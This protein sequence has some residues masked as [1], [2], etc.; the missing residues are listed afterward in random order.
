MLPTFDSARDEVLGLFHT[1]WIADT[2]A[3]NGGS[4][5]PVHYQGTDE[6]DPPAANHAYA[7]IT[8]RHT[9]SRAAAFGQD[10]IRRHTRPGLVTVQVFSPLIVQAGLSFAENAAIIARDAFEGVGT[11]SGIWFRNARIQEIGPTAAWFQV[12]VIAEFE[13]DEVK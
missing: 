2:P 5:I 4:A 7:R 8:I 9:T 11:A 6:G 13:Y 3:I 10:G 1:K 12:N